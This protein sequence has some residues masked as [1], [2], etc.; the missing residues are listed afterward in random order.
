MTEVLMENVSFRFSKVLK[1]VE[2]FS[3]KVEKGEFVYIVGKNAAGKST[4]LRIMCG[5]IPPQK[6]R[7]SLLGKDPH[8][9]PKVLKEVG[10]MID[11]MGFYSDLSLKENVLIFAKEK[12]LKDG[13]E[14]TL[15]E[16]IKIWDIDFNTLYK[17]GSHGMRR[18]AQL[19]LS[20]L[21][22]PQVFIWDEPELAL[23]EKRQGIL[24]N[25]LHDYKSKG[26]TIIIAGT[27]PDLYGDL[28]DKTIHKE[29]IV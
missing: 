27:N 10:V 14:K 19:T 3:L 9:N 11:G 5:I 16:Y 20:L 24:L 2:D 8:R 22:N 25:F 17:R 29:V 7:V 18:I 28:V 12:G 4:L 15:D 6:G 1:I 13:V 21:T 26:E 23:D